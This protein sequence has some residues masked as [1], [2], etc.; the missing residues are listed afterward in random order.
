MDDKET[1]GISLSTML[2]VL[3]SSPLYYKSNELPLDEEEQHLLEFSYQNT[4]RKKERKKT[5]IAVSNI[6]HHLLLIHSMNHD[7]IHTINT[8]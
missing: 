6:H 5:I 8:I 3:P 2:R 1:H 4:E 7:F